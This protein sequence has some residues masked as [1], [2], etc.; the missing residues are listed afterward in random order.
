MKHR[1]NRSP[2][3]HRASGF[4]LLEVLLAFVVFALS[5]TAILEILSGAMRNTTRAKEQTEAALITQSV[6]DQV[7]LDIPLESGSRSN[8]TSGDYRWDLQIYDYSSGPEAAMF[9]E[10]GEMLGVELLE[11]ELQ[12]SWGI[13]PREKTRTFSTVKAVLPAGLGPEL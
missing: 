5:F 13:A 1:R 6:M 7:G 9:A 8:G 3:G 10:V 11:V 2:A 4:T 12:I